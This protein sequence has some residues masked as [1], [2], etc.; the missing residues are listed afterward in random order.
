MD[1]HLYTVESTRFE[2]LMRN[3]DDCGS[4]T[5]DS[6]CNFEPVPRTGR[7]MFTIKPIMERVQSC[8]S[9]KSSD[10]CYVVEAPREPRLGTSTV[11]TL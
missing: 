11:S 2:M 10:E 5:S 8:V 9:K 4:G 1:R 3:C 7:W 6:D